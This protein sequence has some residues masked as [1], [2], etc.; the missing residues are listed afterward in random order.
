MSFFHLL[1]VICKAKYELNNSRQLDFDLE[2][3]KKSGISEDLL[4]EAAKV[5]RLSHYQIIDHKLYR[6]DETMFP[7]RNSGVE[8]FILKIIDKLPD[9]EF[10]LNTRDWPQTVSW[11]SKKFPIF[12]FSKVVCIFLFYS[13]HVIFLHN[14]CF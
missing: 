11:Q 2:P 7:F 12:S 3:W 6:N 4:K 1:K 5:E 13:L 9:S 14:I 10:L 8:H